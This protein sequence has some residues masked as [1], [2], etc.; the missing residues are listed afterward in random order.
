[1][2]AFTNDG[3]QVACRTDKKN[4]EIAAEAFRARIGNYPT[5][6]TDILRIGR[7]VTDGYLREAPSSPDY[8]ITL[9]LAGAV[10]STYCP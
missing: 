6:A 5:E 8:T 2:N 9:S 7:L 10:A 3:K 1:M 4:V